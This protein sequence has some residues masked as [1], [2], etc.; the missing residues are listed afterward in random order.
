[1]LDI[2]RT[3]AF[4]LKI[5]KEKLGLFESKEELDKRKVFEEY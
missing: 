1:L 3:V 5:K 4:I 2:V